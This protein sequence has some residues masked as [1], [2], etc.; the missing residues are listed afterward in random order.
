MPSVFVGTASKL[1]QI[2][3]PTASGCAFR[4]AY[5]YGM[6][7]DILYGVLG[8]LVGGLLIGGLIVAFTDQSASNGSYDLFTLLVPA[9]ACAC[10]G[11][12]I[13]NKLN[14]TQFATPTTPARNTSL[15][16]NLVMT[17]GLIIIPNWVLENLFGANVA[18]GYCLVIVVVG[19]AWYFY[20]KRAV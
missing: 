15:T 1:V 19:L 2:S 6:G 16:M 20:K 7:R 9:I 4:L 8:F 14:H 12:A 5:N 11:I 17:F 10:I 18:I 13:G 3:I